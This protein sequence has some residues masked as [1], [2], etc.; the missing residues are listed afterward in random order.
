MKKQLLY[1]SM[2]GMLLMMNA[3]T[4]YGKTE[5]LDD[6]STIMYFTNSGVQSVECFKVGEPTTYQ[7]AVYKA[8]SDLSAVSNATATLMTET[9]LQ[10]YNQANETQYKMLPA[11]CYQANQK[12]EFQFSSSQLVHTFPVSFDADKIDLLD[13][14]SEYVLPF[15]LSSTLPVNEDKNVILIQPKATTPTVYFQ[16]TDFEQLTV[17]QSDPEKVVFQRIVTLPFENRWEFDCELGLDEDAIEQFNSERGKDYKLLPASAFT[18]DKTVTFTPGVNSAVVN[19]SIDRAG[20]DNGNYL[21][22]LKLKKCTHPRFEVVGEKSLALIGYC[23]ALP[24]IPLTLNMLSANATVEGD[25]TGLLGLIDGTGNGKHYHSNYSGGVIDPIFGHYIQINLQAPIQ[26]LL[27]EYWTRSNT[28][29]GTPLRI[30]L[31]TSNDGNNWTKLAVIEKGLP[32]SA[33]TQ[34]QSGFFKADQPFTYLRWCV[35]KGPGGEMTHPGDRGFFNL[36]DLII[37]GQ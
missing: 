13:K 12:E 11:D 35:T 28:N 29:N 24:N 21:I 14:G 19:I 10:E 23:Y 2:A 17:T 7:V 33:A 20:L 31:F 26:T 25:G 8:G 30:E 1:F 18:Y 36:D 37:Y 5:F 22:P 4:E 16:N 9:E 27:F 34:Y 3:C 6:Y 15:S 32:T